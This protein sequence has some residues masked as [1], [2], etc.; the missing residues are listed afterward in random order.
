MVKPPFPQDSWKNHRHLAGIHGELVGVPAEQ[1]VAA[2][3]A[4]ETDR[5]GAARADDEIEVHWAILS[6]ALQGRRRVL[7]DYRE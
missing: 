6:L 1:R 2:I 5:L 4:V 7:A 3:V